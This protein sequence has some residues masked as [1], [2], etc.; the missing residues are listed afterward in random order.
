MRQ[1]CPSRRPSLTVRLIGLVP[2][3]LLAIAVALPGQAARADDAA[4]IRGVIADQ[5][6]AFQ[7]DDLDAA[8]AHASPG[9]QGKFRSPD[10]FGQ[11]V[12]YGYPMIW[13]PSRW[14]MGETAT[15][16]AGPVQTVLFEDAA[17]ALWEADYS[18][19]EV[20]GVWRI[21]G[22]TLRKIPGVAS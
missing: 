22:V 2:A 5:I 15:T 16:E 1:R 9:I 18:M 19:T 4:A 12:R 20:D 3:L 11:M 21:S 13:R 14:E 10:T 17:G 8:F 7:R 6:A